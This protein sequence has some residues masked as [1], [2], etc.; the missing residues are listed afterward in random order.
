MTNTPIPPTETAESVVSPVTPAVERTTSRAVAMI[1][2]TGVTFGG[3]ALVNSFMALCAGAAAVGPLLWPRGEGI[4]RA[5][6]RMVGLGAAAAWAY[7]L[8]VRPWFLRWGAPDADLDRPLPGDGIVPHAVW[9]ST[10]A[11]TIAAPAEQVW[12]WLVQIGQRRGGFYSYDWLENLA[13]LDIHSADRI[14]PEF[15]HLVVGDFVPAG[16]GEPEQGAGWTVVGIEPGRALLLRVGAPL[17]AFK[18][19]TEVAF[20]A[21]WV[22]VVEP[23]DDRT[24][25][26]IVRWRATSRP[27]ALVVAA[28]AM[29]EL[30]HFVMERKMLLGI[31]QRAERTNQT[32]R[33]A[34]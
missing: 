5:L 24:S 23:L 12:P 4:G 32:V 31:K 7:T 9:R 3:P 20:A 34:L 14:M 25:R 1:R 6:H 18:P 19:A 28:M 21:I 16:P 26:L 13:G 8:A 27:R 33:S 30:A 29:T 11:V 2:S 10:R 15:Q 22:W 17:Q